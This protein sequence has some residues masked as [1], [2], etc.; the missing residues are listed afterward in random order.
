[1]PHATRGKGGH[2]GRVAEV[3]ERITD[4]A[5]K[6]AAEADRRLAP[7]VRKSMLAAHFAICKLKFGA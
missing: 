4:A 1:L 6:A 7:D 2:A 5:R 3:A